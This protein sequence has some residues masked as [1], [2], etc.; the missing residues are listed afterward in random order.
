M[1]STPHSRHASNAANSSSKGEIHFDDIYH[2]NVAIFLDNAAECGKEGLWSPAT[3]TSTSTPSTLPIH[4]FIG[5][6][7]KDVDNSGK[8]SKV[9]SRG[10]LVFVV[11]ATNR[12]DMLDPG[13]CCTLA[14]AYIGCC[15][16]AITSFGCCIEAIACIGN[17]CLPWVLY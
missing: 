5:N 17:N 4:S 10:N 1:D 8:R 6:V 2:H 9:K 14:I 7:D 13:E 12:P 15:I 11:A 16:E 3:N